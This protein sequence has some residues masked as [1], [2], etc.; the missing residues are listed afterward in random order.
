MHI[1]DGFISP[2]LYVPAFLVAAPLWAVAARRVRSRLQ[3]EAIPTLAVMT[4]LAFVLMTV[5]LPLPGGTSVHAAGVSILAVMFGVWASYLSVSLVLLMQALIFGLGGVTSL[6]VNALAVGFV[7]SA[8]AY[9]V[10]RLLKGVNER[11]ALFAAGWLSV[12]V[13]AVLV[14]VALGVQP[15]IALGEDGSPLFFPF[16]LSI[17]LPA[18][19]IP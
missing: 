13:P 12:T 6:P 2:K 15:L 14:A 10:Y 9:S 3:E 7:G 1:P 5:A 17:T 8:I 18:V 19:V 11:G 4:A 16:D